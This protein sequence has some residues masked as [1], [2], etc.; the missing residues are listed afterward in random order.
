MKSDKITSIKRVPLGLVILDNIPLLTMYMF[1]TLII[2]KF[3]IIIAIIYVF[4]SFL[5]IIWFWAKICPHCNYYGTSGCPCGYG[6]ISALFF[7]K[8]SSANFRKIFKRNIIAVYPS[9]FI[10]PVFG[11][12]LL[13]SS[14]STG[15]LF[16]NISF[17]L[18]GFVFIPLIA[19]KV[20]CK[21]CAI[22][23]DCPWMRK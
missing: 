11:I 20:G 13:I 23:Q 6:K 18:V 2:R 21:D 3:S 15:L 9:W 14:Y 10:P 12:Y 1:G 19:K 16:L 17:A 22:K 8:G 5:S 4:Y 7:K